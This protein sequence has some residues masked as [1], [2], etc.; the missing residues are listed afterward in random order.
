MLWIRYKT[1]P[2]P[3]RRGLPLVPECGTGHTT[4]RAGCAPQ[5]HI[6][7]SLQILVA[8]GDTD[9]SGGPAVACTAVPGVMTSVSGA[10]TVTQCALSAN[11]DR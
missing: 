3:A 4:R 7:W 10:K 11:S 1:W 6:L 9:A 2:E 5:I 8:K